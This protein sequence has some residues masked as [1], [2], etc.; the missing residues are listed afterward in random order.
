MTKL[1]EKLEELG[2]EIE[3]TDWAYKYAKKPYS[4]ECSIE[5]HFHKTQQNILYKAVRVWVGIKTQQNI[6]KLQQAFD[7]MQKDLEIL[8]GVE[9]E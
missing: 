4:F 3:D 8:K 2:Y 6:D 9:D 1:E 7:E 5:I